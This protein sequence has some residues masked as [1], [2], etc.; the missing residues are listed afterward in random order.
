MATESSFNQKARS[1]AG[2]IGY[3][4]LMPR[5]A[6]GLGVNPHDP[7]QNIT[8]GV[9][10]LGQLHRQFNGDLRKTV[11]AYNAGPGAVR[12]AGGVPAYRETQRYVQKVLGGMSGNAPSVNI[13][14]KPVQKTPVSIHIPSPVN[15]LPVY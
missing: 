7:K 15:P 5:T 10:Y 9:K 14:P 4:Q 12:R 3:M 1:R 2:A 11:A 6:K 8:G 13:S